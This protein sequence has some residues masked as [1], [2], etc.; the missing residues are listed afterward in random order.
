MTSEAKGV[1]LVVFRKGRSIFLTMTVHEKNIINCQFCRIIR[2]RIV[3]LVYQV[4]LKI[5]L[6]CRWGQ[7]HK[8]KVLNDCVNIISPF[9]S[10]KYF[11]TRCFRRTKTK[12]K[13]LIAMLNQSVVISIL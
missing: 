5:K 4:N 9:S 13:T 1:L 6:L 2:T 10:L 11:H 7:I 3:L 8:F 12:L